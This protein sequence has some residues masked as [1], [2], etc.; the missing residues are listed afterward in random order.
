M[1]VKLKIFVKVK[2]KA[3]NEEVQKIDEINY[4]V[5]VKEPPIDGKANRAVVRVLSDYF[6]TAQSDISLLSG[7]TSRRKI[8]EITK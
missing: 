4:I 3:R 5:S 1:A 7:S 6:Q 2:A 8:F